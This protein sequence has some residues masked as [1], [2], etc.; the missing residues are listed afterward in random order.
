M[1]NLI[2]RSILWSLIAIVIGSLIFG[3]FA[4]QEL[5]KNSFSEHSFEAPSPNVVTLFFEWILVSG[6]SIQL[7]LLPGILGGVVLG[8]CLAVLIRWQPHFMRKPYARIIGVLVGGVVGYLAA[9]GGSMLFSRLGGLSEIL[10]WSRIIGSVLG[11]AIGY[12]LIRM[13][14][15]KL[16]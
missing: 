10:V 6:I 5:Q 2:G 11:G 13:E 14:Q 7:T 4:T 15:R 12:Y 9:V 16:H 3:V 1:K 8:V